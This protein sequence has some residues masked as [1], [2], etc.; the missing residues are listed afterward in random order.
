MLSAV[1]LYACR[2]DVNVT[3]LSVQQHRSQTLTRALQREERGKRSWI[4]DP[5][6]S[7]RTLGRPV[8][9]LFSECWR[10]KRTMTMGEQWMLCW[11]SAG[12]AGILTP[13]FI[14]CQPWLAAA[15]KADTQGRSPQHCGSV[16]PCLNLTLQG[17]P[18]LSL[19]WSILGAKAA[20]S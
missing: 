13:L 17:L 8:T 9:A 3:D 20:I 10:L 1:K 4:V 6:F 18:L 15:P 11:T 12:R 19:P 2:T 14:F 16:F 5:V 7:T